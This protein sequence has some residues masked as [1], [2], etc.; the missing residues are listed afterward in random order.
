MLWLVRLL[1]FVLVASV[2]G[3]AVAQ[4]CSLDE[5]LEAISG[6]AF[7]A[8]PRGSIALGAVC[9]DG[10]DPCEQYFDISNCT[11]VDF[12][13]ELSGRANR[14]NFVINTITPCAAQCA[15][16]S[17]L[18]VVLSFQNE[19]EIRPFVELFRN[20]SDRWNIYRG[21]NLTREACCDRLLD[22]E[23]FLS[24][25]SATVAENAL[26]HTEGGVPWH[27]SFESEPLPTQLTWDER[28]FFV[29]A[30]SECGDCSAKFYMARFKETPRVEQQIK[31]FT[32]LLLR[33]SVMTF[34]VA[35]LQM[36]APLGGDTYEADVR[37]KLVR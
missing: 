20:K 34:P 31:P 7:F 37:I 36:S 16:D 15:V 28:A 22:G 14:L 35:R 30:L 32:A 11:E 10:P 3:S 13:V 6:E 29:K 1:I 17:Y 25:N 23:R 2:A 8:T 24:L 27:S 33:A 4:V 26:F 18:Q 5:G 12:P 9:D 19:P 21:S